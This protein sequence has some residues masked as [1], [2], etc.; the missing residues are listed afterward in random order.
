MAVKVELVRT[1]GFCFGVRRAVRMVDE[2][3]KGADGPVYTL[4]PLIHNPQMVAKMEEMGV[5]VVSPEEEVPPG[6][7]VLRSHGVPPQVE[8]K[9]RSKGHKVLDATC[10]F[11]R[12]AQMYAR[13][14]K[15]EGYEVVIVGKR[16]HEEVEGILGYAGGAHVVWR[17]E[18]LVPLGRPG[19]VGVVAQTTTPFEVFSSVVS[20]LLKRVKHI[21]VYNTICD[22][23]S[24]RQEE[25]AA[26]AKR[27][28]VMIIVGGRNS[29]NTTRL[30]ELCR[31]LG[32]PT[33]HIE[34][35]DEL[36]REWVEGA[37]LV[38]VSA[39]ASTP[40]W[41]V[42]EVTERLKILNEGGK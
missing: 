31:G 15:E 17:P 25:T 40:D 28:D 4:G 9:V 27:A 11:V 35:A 10:P 8:E 5:R 19:K 24:K 16:G 23:T 22:S 29:A 42:E 12:N 39:G 36:R 34:T 21:K 6:V 7:V 30:A 13:S 41:L 18:E 37:S 32:K 1:S 33:Y 26:L 20:E 3:L 38:G 14:L 2:A